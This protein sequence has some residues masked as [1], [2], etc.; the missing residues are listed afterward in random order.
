MSEKLP[1]NLITIVNATGDGEGSYIDTLPGGQLPGESRARIFLNVT[2]LTA[3]TTPTMD[4]SIVALVGGVD[5]LIV[6]FTQSAEGTS[7]QSIIVEGCP[8][9]LKVEYVEGGT[10]A[11]F[12][13]TVDIIRF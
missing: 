5:Q 13:A 2:S 8:R 3:G 10:V 6:A 4:V 11:D 1:I 9:S 12:D 7:Q